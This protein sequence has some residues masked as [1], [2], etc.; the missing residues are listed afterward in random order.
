[1]TELLNRWPE[2]ILFSTIIGVWFAVDRLG[3]WVDSLAR[4]EQQEAPVPTMP[5]PKRLGDFAIDTGL[6]AGGYIDL[7][8][9]PEYER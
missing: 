3:R 7:T 4:D 6:E 2:F 8:P 1:M 9:Q 5:Q